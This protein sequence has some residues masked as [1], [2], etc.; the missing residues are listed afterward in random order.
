VTQAEDA[1]WPS[2]P[3]SVALITRHLLRQTTVDFA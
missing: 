2:N 1:V 3:A